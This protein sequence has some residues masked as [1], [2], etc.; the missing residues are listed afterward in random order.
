[1]TGL[2]FSRSFALAAADA[3]TVL[4]RGQVVAS[5]AGRV[6]GPG[7]QDRVTIRV[8]GLSAAHGVAPPGHPDGHAGV[9]PGDL[10]DARQRLRRTVAAMRARMWIRAGRLSQASDWA[11]QRRVTAADGADHLRERCV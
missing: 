11:T 5:R 9:G 1:M 3:V 8:A 10:A 7:V 6:H 4:R 2:A